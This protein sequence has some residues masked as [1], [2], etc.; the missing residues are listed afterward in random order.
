MTSRPRGHKNHIGNSS[1]PCDEFHLWKVSNFTGG[2]SRFV[3]LFIYAG[4]WFGTME[5]YDFNAGWWFGTMEFCDFNAG[6]WFG[7]MEFY[8]FPF[9]WECHHSN[10]RTH[11]FQRGRYTNHQQAILLVDLPIENGGSFHSY[12][13]VYQRVCYVDIFSG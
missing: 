7:T 5:F 13:T 6:W 11:I 10:C 12:V 8:D 4:W 1:T 2:F 3:L 9:S